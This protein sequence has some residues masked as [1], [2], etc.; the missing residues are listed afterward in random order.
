LFERTKFTRRFRS[1][2][3]YLIRLK[4]FYNCNVWPG[5]QTRRE[6]ALHPP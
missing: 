6:V 2:H 4:R 5:P 1:R 3:R